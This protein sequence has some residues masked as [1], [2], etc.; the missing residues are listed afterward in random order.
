MNDQHRD[1]KQP[2]LEAYARLTDE[3]LTRLAREAPELGE[4]AYASLRA[5]IERHHLS[6]DL[7]SDPPKG[8]GKP[9]YQRLIM[10]R[11]F[12]DLPEALLAKGSLE[13]A[14]IECSLRDD[15]LV[16]LDWFW[17]NLIG[18]VRLM[19]S[20]TDAEVSDEILS[21]PIPEDLEV[22]EVGDYRQP[23]CPQCNS[24]D[25]SYR[26]LNKPVA[27]ISAFLNMPIPL[28]HI[29]WRCDVCH[30]EWEDEEDATRESSEA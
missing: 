23:R 3:Q 27:Y 6:P 5:E 19:V 15:N 18:G 4:E 1:E 29:A 2:F 28:E 10:V 11:R 30:A 13:S 9:E 21:Q 16:R 14:G 20:P 12:R 24:L 25:V 26:E 17:S 8:P 7:I 22:P